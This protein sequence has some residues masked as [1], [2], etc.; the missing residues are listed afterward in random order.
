MPWRAGQSRRRIPKCEGG[1]RSTPHGGAP[2]PSCQSDPG[3]G[4]GCRDGLDP[5][6]VHDRISYHSNLMLPDAEQNIDMP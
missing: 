3:D 4:E 5:Q 1:R 6:E 2:A